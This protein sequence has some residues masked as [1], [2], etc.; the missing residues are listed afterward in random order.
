MPRRTL[1]GNGRP[2]LNSGDDFEGQWFQLPSPETNLISPWKWR[3]FGR[4]PIRRILFGETP[5]FQVAL[6]RWLLVFFR[7]KPYL[8]GWAFLGG[9]WGCSLSFRLVFFQRCLE[10]QICMLKKNG[11]L[12]MWHKGR[13]YPTLYTMDHSKFWMNVIWICRHNLWCSLIVFDQETYVLSTS[14]KLHTWIH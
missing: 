5:Y 1:P 2:G 10:N 3:I 12:Y 7:W 4:R 6:T 9:D 13:I 11:S 14:S 8:V